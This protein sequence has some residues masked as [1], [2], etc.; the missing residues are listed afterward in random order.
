MSLRKS[1]L[2]ASLVALVAVAAPSRAAADWLFTPFIGS[3]FGGNAEVGGTGDSYKNEFE[4]RL[5]YGAT[6]GW[7]GGGII[8]FEADF[9]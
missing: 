3:T 2:S 9:G 4:R 6:L 7:M 8:G 5:N 1:L